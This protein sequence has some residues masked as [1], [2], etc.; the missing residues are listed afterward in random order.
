MILLSLLSIWGH[1]SPGCDESDRRPAITPSVISLD[2]PLKGNAVIADDFWLAANQSVNPLSSNHGHASCW[3]FLLVIF[4]W[5]ILVVDR[6]CVYQELRMISFYF[7]KCW[8]FHS[9]EVVDR[10]SET[11]PQVSEKVIDL[12]RIRAIT[13][14][15]MILL[16]LCKIGYNLMK[17]E[18]L[19][20]TSRYVSR[21]RDKTSNI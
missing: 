2:N 20:P 1:L 19:S 12:P 17:N 11:Q 15:D 10:V 9:L 16:V 14:S 7:D 3:S 5:R 18:K 6:V 13:V 8:Y 4:K 21:Q